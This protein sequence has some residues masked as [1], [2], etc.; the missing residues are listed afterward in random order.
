MLTIGQAFYDLKTRLSIL[1]DDREAA[2]ISHDMLHYITGLDKMQRLTKKDDRFTDEQ[3]QQYNQAKAALVKGRPLQYVTGKAW[4]LGRVF[5][6]NEAVLIPRPE[7]EELVEWVLEDYRAE[8][9]KQILDVGTG[10]G[11]IAISLKLIMPQAE[12]TAFDISARALELAATNAR[13]LKADVQFQQ[14]DFLDSI[15]RE[16]VGGFDIIVS[17]PPYIP[18]HEK[19]R[20]HTNVRDNEPGIALFVPSDDALLFYKAIA[21]FGKTHLKAGG[22]IYCELDADH[23]M[24]TK[25][26]FEQEGYINVEVRADIHRNQRMLKA[27]KAA[28]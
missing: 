19:E 24:E 14:I 1:Y 3:L 5:M 18:E 12:V 22:N 25:D 11:C 6:V 15:Q 2:A 21:D 26:L 7:T 16:M 28:L 17:N 27:G 9:T 4:F 20:L 13:S 23:A 10:S 8:Q